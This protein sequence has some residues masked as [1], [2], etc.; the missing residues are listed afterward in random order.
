MITYTQGATVVE[1]ALAHARKNEF[2]PMTVAVLDTAGQLVAFGRGDHSGLLRERIARGKAHG[3]L[4]M[5]VGSRSLAGRAASH[6]EFIN[7]LVALAEGNLVPVPGGVLIRTADG[8]L[9]GA[10]GVSGHLPDQDED[11]ALRGIAAT[12][13]QADPGA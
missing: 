11:C 6:P 7:S 12:G 4:N 13:L 9:L 10:V 1:H 3:A 2:P 8:N 5:G